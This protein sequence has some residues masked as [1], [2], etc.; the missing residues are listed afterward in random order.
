M[1]TKTLLLCSLLACGTIIANAQEKGFNVGI[2][3]GMN[4]AKMT[5]M[6]MESRLGFNIGA[7]F[8]YNF[9]HHLYLGWGVLWT[10]KGS[11]CDIYGD[12][13]YKTKMKYNPYYL[14]L[15]ISIGGRFTMNDGISIFGETGP[16][17][18]IGVC[19]KI[20][21]GDFSELCGMKNKDFFNETASNRFDSGWGARAGIEIN[22][23]QVHIGYE[24]S[25]TKVVDT[26][27]YKSHNTNLNI[28]V[29]YMF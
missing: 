25:F 6:E 1:R 24:Y 23:F 12:D 27:F 28:G 10:M 19:G 16:Y 22:G 11:K 29:T 18:A 13:N 9:N 17:L 26:D 21:Y 14:E 8:E 20:K 2:T 3:A 5:N 15:P 4:V 7:K